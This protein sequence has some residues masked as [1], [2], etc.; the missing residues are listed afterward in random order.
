MGKED[1]RG[2]NL[3]R[4]PSG[5]IV[6][7]DDV[8]LRRQRSR[9]MA[10]LFNPPREK[11]Y[12]LSFSMVS[13]IL[14][15]IATALIL[16]A[17]YRIAASGGDTSVVPTFTELLNIIQGAPAVQIPMLGNI[18]STWTGQVDWGYFYFLQVMFQIVG[19]IVDVFLFICN[20]ML[21]IY[22]YLYYFL[23]WIFV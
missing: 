6:D 2:A 13:R 23:V 4:T 10:S 21:A 3:I 16:I 12:N 17:I 7:V 14:G 9:E 5:N 1:F 19:V 18:F 8:I 22:T 15:L 11:E 20:G